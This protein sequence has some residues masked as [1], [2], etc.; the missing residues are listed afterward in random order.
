MSRRYN[1][2]TTHHIIPTSREDEGF[3]TS[4]KE[5]K[6]V[7]LDHIHQGLHLQHYNHT[8]QEQLKDWMKTNGNVISIE[9]RKRIFELIELTKDQFYDLKFLK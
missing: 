6:I 8:P 7:L 2:Y 1:R 9:V 4:Q 5:N 3:Y